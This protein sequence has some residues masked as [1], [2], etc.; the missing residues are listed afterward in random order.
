MKK[1]AATMIRPPVVLL[2]SILVVLGF[3][4]SPVDAYPISPVPLWNLVE[5]SDLVVLADV[6]EITNEGD[7]SDASSKDPNTIIEYLDRDSIARLRVRET[8]KGEALPSVEVRFPRFLIYTSD[9]ADER[10]SV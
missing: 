3:L 4:T 8:W 2:L 10:S 7:E 6:V 5:N 1:E 9:A